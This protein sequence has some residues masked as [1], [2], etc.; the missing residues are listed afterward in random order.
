VTG[1]ALA[2]FIGLFGFGGHFLGWPDNNG[3]VQ[4]GLAPRPGPKAYALDPAA[5]DGPDRAAASSVP[6]CRHS[7][8]RRRA[9]AGADQ[10]G[11][12]LGAA[13][14]GEASGRTTGSHNSSSRR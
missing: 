13:G 12:T 6:A 9:V 2:M 5:D 7:V 14:S 3:A 8:S 10:I 1:L 11:R 4:L